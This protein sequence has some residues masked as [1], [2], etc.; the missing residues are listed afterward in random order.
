M[1]A[2][3]FRD[4]GITLWADAAAAQLV[5]QRCT[6]CLKNLER[7]LGAEAMRHTEVVVPSHAPRGEVSVGGRRL[8]L[9]RFERAHSPGDLAVLDVA[10]GVLFSGALVSIGRIPDVRDADTTAWREALARLRDVK[11]TR[12][13]P[14]Y[15]PV[16]TTADI[17]DHLAYLDALQ[18][19]V[20]RHLR[21][22]DGL[23]ATER[24]A[25]L[26]QYREWGGYPGLHT[27]NVHW[28]YL[29]EERHGFTE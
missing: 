11:P 8:R 21:D 10:S 1:G 14:G 27:R 24:E 18:A 25:Q 19:Q 15:G 7:L 16:G 22:G 3:A 20:H 2:A 26:P 28:M 12:L 4:A 5:G 23:V 9:I 6:T 29:R 13:V 17:A